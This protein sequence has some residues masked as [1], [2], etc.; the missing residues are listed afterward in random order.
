MPLR[1]PPSTFPHLIPTSV[2]LTP[3]S[4][5]IISFT[6]PHPLTLLKSY[7]FKNRGR[8]GA[9]PDILSNHLQF[10]VH[11]SKFRIPQIL[12]LP[13][14]RK[15]RGCGG[16]LPILVHFSA[17][18]CDLCVSALSFPSLP[19]P[20]PSRQSVF[21]RR[22]NDFSNAFARSG[23]PVGEELSRSRKFKLTHYRILTLLSRSRKFKLA[24]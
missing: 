7:R 15:Q 2:T 24:H 13:L 6:D 19:G 8:E 3:K 17:L 5:R 10:S 14:L 11:T 16:I 18:L 20:L 21:H 9:Q 1:R 4:H 12:C 23:V 22:D